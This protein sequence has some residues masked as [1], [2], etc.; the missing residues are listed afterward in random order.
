MAV[1]LP[2]RQLEQF[3]GESGHQQFAVE[4][5]L[6]GQQRP[7]ERTQIIGRAAQLRDSRLNDGRRQGRQT[8][9]V[10]V[11]A[12]AGSRVGVRLPALVQNPLGERVEGGIER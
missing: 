8:A 10:L 4:T 5:S 11:Q 2:F 12:G 3:V 9:V 7:V 1:R 6:L